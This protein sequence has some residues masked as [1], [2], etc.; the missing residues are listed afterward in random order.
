MSSGAVGARWSPPIGSPRACVATSSLR[1]RPIAR[2]VSSPLRSRVPCALVTLAP[3]RAARSRRPHVLVACALS[4]PSRCRP[5]SL[6]T[7]ALPEEAVRAPGIGT[8]GAS[9]QSKRPM[10][11][12]ARHSP[13]LEVPLVPLEVPFAPTGGATRARWRYR[14]PLGA[15]LHGWG[16]APC[17]RASAD[18][19]SNSRCARAHQLIGS[20][21]SV[22]RR[23]G[24]ASAPSRTARNLHPCRPSGSAPAGR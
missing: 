17:C 7:C 8:S 10:N 12:L 24:P 19:F 22:S 20:L 9:V 21:R 3:S 23:T 5:H 14:A 1:H 15:A 2:C 18:R 11:A 13:P 16:C 4:A 6:V